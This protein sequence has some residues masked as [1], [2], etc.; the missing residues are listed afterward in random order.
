MISQLY[1]LVYC[2]EEKGRVFRRGFTVSGTGNEHR[3]HAV[4]VTGIEVFLEGYE[5]VVDREADPDE[6]VHLFSGPVSFASAKFR[7]CPF[8]KNEEGP[9]CGPCAANYCLSSE[10]EGNFVC[11]RCGFDGWVGRPESRKLVPSELMSESGITQG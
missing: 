5:M 6:K 7:F 3:K 9:R 1:Q 10:A 4:L 11:P 2:S 8:C